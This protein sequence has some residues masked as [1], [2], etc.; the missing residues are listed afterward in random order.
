MNEKSVSRLALAR[1]ARDT[2]ILRVRA[3]RVLRPC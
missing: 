1:Q 2:N 3:F